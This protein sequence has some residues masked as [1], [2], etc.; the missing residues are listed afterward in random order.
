M[1]IDEKNPGI[2]LSIFPN[3]GNNLVK[4]SGY[5]TAENGKEILLNCYDE[6]GRQVLQ[7]NLQPGGMENST[8]IDVKEWTPGIYMFVIHFGNQKM[9]KQFVKH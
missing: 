2:N 8:L 3:P 1:G 7:K 5:S 9:I 4:I 6:Q